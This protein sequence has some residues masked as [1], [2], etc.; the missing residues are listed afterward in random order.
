ML[1]NRE[2]YI[3]HMLHQYTGKEMFVELFGLL[4]GLEQEWVEQGATS[5][6]L[7]LKAFGWDRVK[8]NRLGVHTGAITNLERKIIKDT[9]TE[10]IEIDKMGRTTKLC[11]NSATIPL[12]LTYP[13]ETMDDWLKIKHWYVFQESRIDKEKLLENKKNKENGFLLYTSIPGGFDEP[14]QLLG[15]ENLCYAFYE[16]P[17]LIHDIL[18]TITD[19]CVKTL[20]RVIDICGV[21]LISVHEDLAGKS[22]PLIGPSQICEFIKPYFQRVWKLAQE[23]G[24]SIF[25]MDSDGN[26]NPVIDSFLECGINSIFPCEPGSGMDIV[27]IKK[28]YGNKLSLK[29]GIDKY[30]LRES[31]ES[32]RKELEYKMCSITKGGG[33]VFALDHRIPN[34]VPLENYKFY[35]NLGREMLN[36]P[37]ITPDVFEGMAF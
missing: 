22:G 32:I 14:R 12:P 18:S 10:R 23:G 7:S 24:A 6:E 29:G 36:L 9:A 33:V 2:E 20:E 35:V 16:Q 34:G 5:D 28:K 8:R 19:T 21:D 27:E 15:E 30:V 17:E 11:K 1:W 3:A 4:V 25:S 31:K 13:V 37:P 26:I